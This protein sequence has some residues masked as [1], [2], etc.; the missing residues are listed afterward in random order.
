MGLMRDVH[1]DAAEQIRLSFGV[2][3]TPTIWGSVWISLTASLQDPSGV[4]DR[5]RPH[6]G[7]EVALDGVGR[8]GDQ[9]GAQDDQV[10]V[11]Q[12]RQ[13]VSGTLDIWGRAR[14]FIRRVPIAMITVSAS[15]IASGREDRTN[16]PAGRTSGDS[17]PSSMNRRAPPMVSSA[18]SSMCTPRRAGPWPGRAG[19]KPTCSPPPRGDLQ[20]PSR[21]WDQITGERSCGGR[22]EL[23]PASHH[24]PEHG[25]HGSA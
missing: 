20:G 1:A 7:T 3:L 25:R 21:S 2:K 19:G 17:A 9:R 6:S 16:D 5:G 12:M 23:R 8:A 11:G 15:R 18:V 24:A 14:R 4:G 13:Q 10:A 22:T